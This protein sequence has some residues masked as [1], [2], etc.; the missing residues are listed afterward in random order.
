MKSC[1]GPGT[2]PGTLRQE[3][4]SGLPDESPVLPWELNRAT[5][6]SPGWSFSPSPAE[7]RLDPAWVRE[8]PATPLLTAE[9]GWGEGFG[10]KG[11]SVS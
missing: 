10:S 8:D 2:F 5:V 6:F 3:E 11:H 1:A 4:P 7:P 9:C